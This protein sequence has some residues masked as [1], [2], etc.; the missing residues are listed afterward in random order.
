[1]NEELQRII[2]HHMERWERKLRKQKGSFYVNVP[3]PIVLA[4]GKKHGSN[5]VFLKVFDEK[6]GKVLTVLEI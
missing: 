1:M 5:I 2:G 6:R 4:Y 3:K